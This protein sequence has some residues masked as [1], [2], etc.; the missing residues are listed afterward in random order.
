[1]SNILLDLGTHNTEGL[2]DI[3]KELNVQ[4]NDESWIIHTFE[5]NPI[6]D[7]E[8]R[9]KQLV[10]YNITL[11]KKAVWIKD[12][13]VRFKRAGIDGKSQ[14]GYVEEIGSDRRYSDHYDEIEIEC[15]NF[16]EFIK[17]FSDED[18]IYIKMDIEFAE[19]NVLDA[20]IESGWNKNIKILGVE[21]HGTNFDDFKGKPQIIK[22]K[23]KDE[24]V[25]IKDWR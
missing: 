21:W 3:I 7:T 15:I 23:L 16:I 9:I 1:M 17:Q 19:Y 13:N 20:M 2:C 12:G 5:P 10:G 4:P 11:H 6:L 14:G 8:N 24:Q 18:N 25:I 22:D